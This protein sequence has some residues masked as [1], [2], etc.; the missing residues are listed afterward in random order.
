MDGHASGPYSIRH[1][2]NSSSSAI[3]LSGTG[4]GVVVQDPLSP[5]LRPLDADNRGYTRRR[6]S[7][8]NVEG[9]PDTS[10]LTVPPAPEPGPSNLTVFGKDPFF[11]SMDRPARKDSSLF[12]TS[13]L[14]AS[15]SPLLSTYADTA[16]A[17]DEIRLIGGAR[18]KVDE[19]WSLT[20]DLSVD[21][22]RSAGMSSRPRRQSA[23]P[24]PILKRTITNAFHRASVRVVNVRG[25]RP[26]ARVQEDGEG[27]DSGSTLDGE[28]ETIRPS[29]GESRTLPSLPLRGRALGILGPTNPLRETLYKI[30]DHPYVV[31]LSCTSTY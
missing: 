28:E 16:S 6:L 14:D 18:P 11:S 22:E 5:S 2:S 20:S 9:R 10:H 25:H 24:S 26:Y 30:L 31:S 13:H 19:G 29:V 4:L 15:S 12:S 23:A 3:D 21:S 1:S 8:S 7:W 27:S 17:D